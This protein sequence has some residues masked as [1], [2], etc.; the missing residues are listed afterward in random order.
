MITHMLT[1]CDDEYVFCS[2]DLF[3]TNNWNC[4]DNFKTL[5]IVFFLAYR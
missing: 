2:T 3:R 4:Y 5:M 1:F